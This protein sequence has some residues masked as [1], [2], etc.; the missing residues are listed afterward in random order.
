MSDYL[1]G[2]T[3]WMVVVAMYV[4]VALPL[5]TMGKKTDSQ[6]PWFAFV[7]ILNTILMLE[8]AGKELWWF[9]LM[10]VPCVN[11]IVLVI[12]WMS[13]AEAMEKPGWLG[14][15]ML[16]PGVNIIMPFYLAYG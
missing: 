4:L 12:V 13:I 3:L 11:I 14:A 8:I 10:L 2:G 9:L 15:L 7:P 5:Y 16:V 6:H 1:A